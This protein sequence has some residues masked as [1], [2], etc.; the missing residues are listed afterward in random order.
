M[1][2]EYVLDAKEKIG[3]NPEIYIQKYISESVNHFSG[4][5]IRIKVEYEPS[6]VTNAILYDFAGENVN[7]VLAPESLKTSVINE[8]KSAVK[9]Y[10]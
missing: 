10:K 7:K 8:L 1:S 9:H 4:E 3:P 2:N 5:T 6:Q